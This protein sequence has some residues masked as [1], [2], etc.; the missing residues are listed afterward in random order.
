[1]YRVILIDDEPWTLKGI[2]QTFH[3]NDYGL[4]VIGAYTFATEALQEILEKKPDAVFTDI[5][6]PIISGIDILNSI[7]KNNL[8][9]EVIVISGFGQFDYAQEVIRHGAFDYILKPIDEEQTDSLLERL[10]KRLD[11]K[12]EEKKRRI[13]EMIIE[14]PEQVDPEQYGLPGRFP[15]YQV[16]VWSDPDRSE[17]MAFLRQ[18]EADY[19]EIMMSSKY[20]Y[21]LNCKDDLYEVLKQRGFP[22]T[23][24]VSRWSE[25]ASQIPKLIT[26]AAAAALDE[27]ITRESGTYR[28]RELQSGKLVPLILRI[29]RMLNEGR[30][31]DFAQLM[32]QLPQLFAENEYGIEDLCYLWNQI[33]MHVE[34]YSQDRS[35]NTAL[36]LFDWQQLE[37]KFD[38]I[39]AMYQILINDVQF[40]YDDTELESGE[41]ADAGG[42]NFNKV[43]KY[44]NKNYHKQ[45]KLKDL[46]E[47]F[48]INKNYACYLF[49][50][51]TGMTYS[52]YLNK[53][54][55]ERARGML[56]ATS[57]T[58]AEVA[59]KAGY[60]DYFYFSKLFKK[61]YGVTP[62][63]Y[64]QKPIRSVN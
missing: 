8:D 13:L 10:Q 53:I 3:W 47:M 44:L 61:T 56:A 45:L 1:M 37:T 27:F 35:K 5:R 22:V 21:I 42:A 50:R 2:I 49:K 60:T 24:G 16:V 46:S 28:Y 39:E 63:Q 51:Y 38:G 4:E 31:M 19:I 62:S 48:Y 30:M 64:R 33:T 41:E 23:L 36:E 11:Q 20:Y 32:E 18:Q 55:M 25:N 7:R 14:D 12:Q 26:Q 34:L 15:G 29:T 59:E 17:L 40:C 43:L 54:R 57:Y 58:I 52:E 6:M 9:T